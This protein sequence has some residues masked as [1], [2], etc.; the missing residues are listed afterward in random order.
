MINRVNM[1][2]MASVLTWPKYMMKVQVSMTLL[3][4]APSMFQNQKAK[5]RQ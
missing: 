5:K 2:L 3:P 4:T 1:Q